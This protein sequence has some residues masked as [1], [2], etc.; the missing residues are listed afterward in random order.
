M[1]KSRKTNNNI[2]RKTYSRSA[3]GHGSISFCVYSVLYIVASS[4]GA[5][6][7]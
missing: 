4:N 2:N 3:A 6:D 5:D 1:H 7:W